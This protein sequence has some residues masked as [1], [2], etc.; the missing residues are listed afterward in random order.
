MSGLRSSGLG[1]RENLKGL[2]FVEGR[3]L[4]DAVQTIANLIRPSRVRFI[5]LVVV[6][7]LSVILETFGFAMI[8]PLMESLLESDSNSSVGQGFSLLFSYFGMQATVLNTSIVF[9]AVMLTKNALKIVREYLRSDYAYTFKI[10]AMEKITKSYFNMPYKDY[11]KLKHGDLVNNTITE[12]QNASMGLLQLTELITGIITVPAFVALMFVSSYQ[13]TFSMLI[14]ALAVYFF[15]NRPIKLYA[16]R[17]GNRE[18]FLNQDISSQVSEDFSAM[19]H[20]RIL[21]I[22]VL[23]RK[24]L[25]R[26]LSQIKSILVKWD[27]ISASTLPIA[28]TVMVIVIVGYFSYISM[29]YDKSHFATVLPIVSMIVVVAYKTMSQFS[30]L[31]VNKMSVERYLPAMKLVHSLIN[32]DQ[33]EVERKGLELGVDP[34]DIHD[35]TIGFDSV[36]FSYNGHMQ[37]LKGASF[38]IP[39]GSV[40]VITGPS[41]SGKSTIVDLLMGLHAPN[42]GNITIGEVSLKDVNIKQWRKSIGYVG[43]DVFLF[44]STIEENICI[45]SCDVD[46][47]LV[48]CVCEDVGLDSFIMNLPEG[49]NT[50]VGDRGA[51]L[52]GGQRQ[53]V[54]IAR[55]LIKRPDILILD[56]AT[57][58]LDNKTATYVIKN[59]IKSMKNKT[60]IVITHRNDIL[61]YANYVYDLKNG[62][63]IQQ[64]QGK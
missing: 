26:S 55:A 7:A 37:V 31:L 11:V 14:M 53:R 59:I 38:D 28:E 61:K 62:E 39:V 24:K 50:V 5:S 27:T 57:S 8:I 20:I 64:S 44:H 41:G 25:S 46:R 29:F 12:T 18:I 48:R 52:S 10:D 40:T 3:M 35:K 1:F 45:D 54:S 30:R 32:H 42:S 6:I 4:S 2:E 49:Y 34:E 13:L 63:L 19:K 33:S 51:M 21:G 47:K 56:E 60:I 22:G 23:L 36:N 17:V 9:L 58:A 43:Q 16:E 15:I